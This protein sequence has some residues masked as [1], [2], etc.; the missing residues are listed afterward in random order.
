MI[1]RKL[2]L[3]VVFLLGKNIFAQPT[4][5]L[6]NPERDYQKAGE[7]FNSG[8][9]A[10]AYPL[11]RSL[12]QKLSENSP[13]DCAYMHDNVEY[14]YIVCE[15][16][17]Q[18]S[19]AET[20]AKRFIATSGNEMRVNQMAFYLAH[21]FFL[22]GDYENAT[23]FFE[24]AGSNSLS[25][26]QEITS[27]FERAYSLFHLKKNEQAKLLFDEVRHFK[28]NQYTSSATYYFGYLSFYEGDFQ[29]AAV[30]LNSLSTDEMYADAVPYYIARSMY[31]MGKKEEALQYGDSVLSARGGG[32]NRRE[33]QLL[34]AQLYFEKKDYVQALPLLVDYFSANSRVS[35]EV[36]YELSYCYFKTG[37]DKKA[38]DGFRQLS[39]EKDSLGQNSMFILGDLYLKAKDK[40]NARSAFQF[41]ASNSSDQEQQRISRLN[42]AKLSY[43]L[44]YQ[45]LAI[46]ETKK[47][48]KDYT[49]HADNNAPENPYG[50]VN[51]AK[52]LLI[53]MMANTNNFDEG[54]EIFSGLQKSSPEA[55]KV[56]ARLLYGKGIQLVNDQRI[57]DADEL[58]SKILALENIPAVTP[59]ANF[60]KGEIAYRQQRYSD[61]IRYL[62]AFTESKSPAQSEANSINANYN[63]GYSWFQK[64][65]YKSAL[66]CFEKITTVLKPV[67]SSIEQDAYLRSADCYFMLKDFTKSRQMYESVSKSKGPQSDYALYQT[68]IIAGIKGSKEKMEILNLLISQYPTSPLSLEAR[69]ELAITCIDDQR[70]KEA[71][72][73]LLDL[74]DDTKASMWASQVYF[75][76]GL[77]H[78]NINNNKEALSA[79][80]NLLKN[81]P[82]ST[83]SQQSVSMIRDIYI[84][85]NNPDGYLE[86]MKEN[87]INVTASEADSLSFVAA[88]A[89]YESGDCPGTI[90][91]YKNYLARYPSGAYVLEANY[92]MGSCAQKQKDTKLALQCFDA[93]N[94]KGI[95]RY[96]E[97]ATLEAARISYFENKDFAAA[98]KYF[99]ALMKL[100]INPENQLEAMRGLVRC[101]YQLKDFSTANNV[102]SDLVTRKGI[103]QDDKAIAFLVLGR[104]KEMA[105][106][107]VEAIKAYRNVISLNKSAWGAEARYALALN[108]FL[109]NDLSGAENSAM[110]V[111]KE[112]GSYELWVIKSYLLLGDIFTAQK[113]YFNAKATY[114]SISQNA[115]I[116]ELK[117][118]AKQKLENVML[119]EK[120]SSKIG[121]P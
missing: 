121:K 7:Y 76:L 12:Q 90:S 29:T 60:W 104:A 118:E 65:E 54:I 80:K 70:F 30:A 96:Y 42:Y 77:C 62:N 63:L 120:Q 49:N 114:E 105:S 36:L 26:E 55:R 53:S 69:L 27:K 83:E 11:L 9:Y 95:S 17:L 91:S 48:I 85:D 22:Q 100:S 38:I 37:N 89:K 45:D 110:S 50:H 111:I 67:T 61:A 2:L 106:D 66:S 92:R 33:L 13:A 112:T 87:G 47:Y 41:C 98:R 117:T 15:L 57:S 68:A 28:Q 25:D 97:A 16:R 46:A 14:W 82:N 107:T 20:D 34:T 35:K 84:E 78:F 75:N 23:D 72:P 21:Y 115:S 56:Y 24:K 113:D 39:S 58:F 6:T 59:Y 31:S 4:H 74:K 88:S 43:E 86:L 8:D 108:L 73:L 103:S 44:G 18:Q 81:Y 19:V 119:L 64:G 99:E 79:F 1:N 32:E 3:L 94:A 5:V 116:P 101:Y 51:E 109:Q 52:E 10:L 40:N 102:A 71:I 93:V